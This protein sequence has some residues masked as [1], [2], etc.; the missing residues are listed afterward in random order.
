M[1]VARIGLQQWDKGQRK[2]QP[3]RSN[4][5][6]SNRAYHCDVPVPT[7]RSG[8]NIHFNHTL[9]T[10]SSFNCCSIRW[11]IVSVKSIAFLRNKCWRSNC[12]FRWSFLKFTRLRKSTNNLEIFASGDSVIILQTHT[13]KIK[14]SCW[15]SKVILEYV[16]N[17]FKLFL[18][19]PRTQ[20][21]DM[22]LTE[23]LAFTSIHFLRFSQSFTVTS[24]PDL[25][26]VYKERLNGLY[27]HDFALRLT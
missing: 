24:H 15:N 18:M 1:N 6:R 17:T 19:I 8:R 12:S 2:G 25:E 5:W 26:R 7:L 9:I 16:R 23:I 11:C 22:K 10:L 21:S 20:N 13:Y 4:C 27:V 14:Q 3:L